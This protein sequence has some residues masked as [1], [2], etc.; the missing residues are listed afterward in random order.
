MNQSKAPS[1]HITTRGSIL[2]N[3]HM[4]LHPQTLTHEAPSPHITTRGSIPT[5]YHTRL[6]PRTL[7][8]EAPSPHITTRGSILTHDG[9]Q[10][11]H[12]VTKRRPALSN[13]MFTLVTS[14]DI[15]ESVS[16][17]PIQ[18]CQR[19]SQRPKKGCS[20]ARLTLR[21]RG[22][23]P[24]EA[25]RTQMEI[26]VAIFLK[27]RSQSANLASGKWPPQSQ[28]AHGRPPVAIFLKPRTSHDK[29]NGISQAGVTLAS[30]TDIEGLQ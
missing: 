29:M 16:H 7:P 19:E 2:T 22:K 10:G 25:T 14:E 13:P 18:R 6:H 12:R 30:F 21:N 8:H 17:T 11:K 3:Y 9:N 20:K 24:R 5:H 15:A 26:A 4:R 27:P 1:S 23:W 28:S